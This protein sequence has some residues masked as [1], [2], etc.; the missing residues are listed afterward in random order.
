M[1]RPWRVDFNSGYEL[2]RQRC[3]TE[4]KPENVSPAID[5]EEPQGRHVLLH[6]YSPDDAG[7]GRNRAKPPRPTKIN[8]LASSRLNAVSGA[9]R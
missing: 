9:T 8:N 5:F 4:L 2:L 6:T 1:V 3:D 7:A